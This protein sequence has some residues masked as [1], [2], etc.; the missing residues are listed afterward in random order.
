MRDEGKGYKLFFT[1]IDSKKEI[2]KKFKYQKECHRSKK[3]FL[4]ESSMPTKFFFIN[5]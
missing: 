4:E 1:Y 2:E 5:F 3:P